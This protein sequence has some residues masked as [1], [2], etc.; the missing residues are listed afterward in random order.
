MSSIWLKY[1][2]RDSEIDEM[3]QI[4]LILTDDNILELQIAVH[5]ANLVH[6]AKSLNL[7]K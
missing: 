5:V 4:F 6:L 7:K 2:V 3:N 1:R